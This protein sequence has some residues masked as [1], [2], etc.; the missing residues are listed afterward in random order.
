MTERNYPLRRALIPAAV[1]LLC[2]AGLYL[3]TYFTV[4]IHEDNEYGVTGFL[5]RQGLSSDWNLKG[6]WAH[7]VHLWNDCNGRLI[8]KFPVPVLALMPRWLFSLVNACVY[9]LLYGGACKV[10]ALAIG[11]RWRGKDLN[12]SV[13]GFMATYPW[14][15][16]AF[17][18]LMALFFPWDSMMMLVSYQLGYIWTSCVV[19]WLVYY[20]CNP[21]LIVDGP[22]W[23]FTVVLVLA[24]VAGTLHELIPCVLCCAFIVPA[25]WSGSRKAVVRRLLLI[26]ALFVGFEILS[27]MPGHIRR[28]GYTIIEFDWRRLF[29]T[30]KGLMPGPSAM[31]GVIYLLTLAVF[32]VWGIPKLSFRS[33]WRKVGGWLKPGCGRSALWMVTA[34]TIGSFVA[35]AGVMSMFG[36]G[37]IMSFGIVLPF[38]GGLALLGCWPGG[39]P[40]W[41]GLLLKAVLVLVG[42]CAVAVWSV[43][44]AL[45]RE[46]HRQYYLLEPR[47]IEVGH[48]ATVYYDLPR[49]WYR[50]YINPNPYPWM[51][52]LPMNTRMNMIYFNP[53]KDPYNVQIVPHELFHMERDADYADI[54][55]SENPPEGYEWVNRELGILRYRNS[56]LFT[57]P[58]GLELAVR[59][60]NHKHYVATGGALN[61]DATFADG[62]SQRAY[63]GICEFFTP[64]TRSKA[65]WLEPALDSESMVHSVILTADDLLVRGPFC[66]AFDSGSYGYFDF[67]PNEPLYHTKILPED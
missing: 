53:L 6:I 15:A 46:I 24:V 2:V 28:V 35:S 39:I 51:M 47:L 58:E 60:L 27:H 59:V 29:P 54:I 10:V 5:R 40:R 63:F 25:L 61:F 26:V 65:Y 17:P 13:V 57:N 52:V 23:S 16:S 20:F 4:P 30:C 44:V 66:F 49:M 21:K 36:G 37:R 62:H 64:R 55:A 19:V 43:S 8:D 48:K 67:F 14:L 50:E 3:M 38:I 1:L 41:F 42:V 22:T 34:V 31:P 45:T 9:I 32:V 7:M 18:L 33:V 11:G 56:Y 12:T